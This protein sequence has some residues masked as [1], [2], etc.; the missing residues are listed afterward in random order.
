M[1]GGLYDDNDDDN[2]NEYNDDDNEDYNNAGIA[3]DEVSIGSK[4]YGPQ[5]DVNG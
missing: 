4:E 3:Q 5:R 1:G 2:D